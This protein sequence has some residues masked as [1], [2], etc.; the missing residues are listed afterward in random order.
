MFRNF[1]T[2]VFF[3]KSSFIVE[4]WCFWYP[5]T[6]R[7][8]KKHLPYLYISIPLLIILV[9]VIILINPQKN[10]E[11]AGIS[12]PSLPIFFTLLF[13][14][15]FSLLSFL[16]LHTRRGALVALFIS[17]FLLLRAAGFREFYYVVIILVI[18]IL[19]ELFYIKR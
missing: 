1:K 15:L 12:I 19:I 8:R 3:F 4:E 7:A 18:L 13:L 5:C 16:L 14:F 2:T 9:V 11:I 10:L 17:S 6:M